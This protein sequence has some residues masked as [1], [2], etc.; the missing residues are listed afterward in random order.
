MTTQIGHE[1]LQSLN[2]QLWNS[3]YYSNL[4]DIACKISSFV[5]DFLQTNNRKT[6][7]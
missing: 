5:E 6:F 1:N 2:F 3:F 4:A 7:M